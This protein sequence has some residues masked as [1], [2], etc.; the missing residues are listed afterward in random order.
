MSMPGEIIDADGIQDRGAEFRAGKQIGQIQR[1]TEGKFWHILGTEGPYLKIQTKTANTGIYYTRLI[2]ADDYHRPDR[3][4]TH[5]PTYRYPAS[6]P[7]I[8]AD[9]CQIARTTPRRIAQPEIIVAREM[10]Q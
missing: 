5:I 8:D 10:A 2:R 1:A 9:A 7:I 3:Y 6:M 4:R